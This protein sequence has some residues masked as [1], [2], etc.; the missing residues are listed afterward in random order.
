MNSLL[1]KISQTLS[2]GK[3]TSA[4]LEARRILSFICHRSEDEVVLLDRELNTTEKKQLE[5]II[6]QRLMHKPLDKIL[7]SKGFYKY[8]FIVSEDVLSPRPDT[9]ILLEE[10]IRLLP[11]SGPCKILDLG[12]GSGCILLSLLKESKNWHG[13]GVDISAQAI[14]IAQQNASLLGI[15]NQVRWINSGWFDEK[16]PQ[17]LDSPF[18]MIVSNPPYIPTQDIAELEDDVKLYDPI[19]A[20]DGG[21]DGLHHYRQIAKV[22]AP[23]LKESGYILLEV[24]IYQAKQ[25]AEI[26][27]KQGFELIKIVSDFGQIERCVILKK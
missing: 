22:S 17:Y 18:D 1:N 2:Q 11:K 6:R 9:E 15:E 10:A 12:T 20:L 19:Q 26:F 13:Q 24:G 16:L 25:V 3:I 5:E 4:R 21:E 27:C 23:L 7:G 8:D 14:R